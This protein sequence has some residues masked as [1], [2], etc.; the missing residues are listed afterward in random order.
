M[1]AAAHQRYAFIIPTQADTGPLLIAYVRPWSRVRV[2]DEN[3]RS[4]WFS[5]LECISIAMHNGTEIAP[6]CP[7]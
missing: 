4:G 5:V 6:L 3:D 2:N 1:V 7:Q